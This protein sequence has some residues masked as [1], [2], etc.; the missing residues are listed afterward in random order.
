MSERPMGGGRRQLNR[1]SV[2]K[3][4]DEV[5]G[6]YCLVYGGKD[7]H[8]NPEQLPPI[9]SETV[10]GNHKPL[11]L[12]IGCGRGEFVVEMGKQNPGV[13][14]VGID[15]HQ[16]ALWDGINH[17]NEQHLQNVKFVKSDA[18]RI[19]TKVP[20]GSVTEVYVLFPP[21]VRKRK[22]MKKDFFTSEFISEIHRCLKKGGTL[23]F[24]T[25]HEDY[26]LEKKKLIETANLFQEVSLAS[27]L[28]GGTTW[29]QKIWENHGLKTWRLELKK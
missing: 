27:G 5:I 16:K 8:W 24:A 3:P 19:L 21:P 18:R 29:Y 1:F 15:F 14:Y 17:A 22:H 4:A 11:V 6:S 10:F 7:L 2:E 23:S 26:F 28:E 20:D 12:D 25:D 9:D 13:N